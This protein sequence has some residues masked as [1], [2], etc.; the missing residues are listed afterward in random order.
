MQHEQETEQ[1]NE[2]PYQSGTIFAESGSGS[3]PIYSSHSSQQGQEYV[4]TCQK[5]DYDKALIN[6]KQDSVSDQIKLADCYFRGIGVEQDYTEAFKWYKKAADQGDFW[7]KSQLADCY[8]Y[9]N[10]VE[11]NYNQAVKWLEQVATQTLSDRLIDKLDK[12]GLHLF[13][14]EL[15]KADAKA[16]AQYQLGYCYYEGNGI[17]QDH[18][19]AVEWF[20]KAA[21]RNEEAK[22][23]LAECYLKGNGVKKDLTQGFN[24]LEEFTEKQENPLAQL[25]L[26]IRYYFC[27][28]MEQNRIRAISLFEKASNH[29]VFLPKFRQDKTQARTMLG[30]CYY[31]E[32]GVKD[33][34]SA[35][36]C[37]ESSSEERSEE[38]ND[39]VGHLWLASIYQLKNKQQFEG[40]NIEDNKQ[41]W[42]HPIHSEE[43]H[44]K[45]QQLDI[46]TLLCRAAAGFFLKDDGYDY[47]D[48][49]I[50]DFIFPKE[51]VI[52]FLEN[53]DFSYAKVILAF[54]YRCKNEKEKSLEL[55]KKADKENNIIASYELGKYYKELEY[56]D[57]ATEYL[58]AV[59]QRKNS[60]FNKEKDYYQ[61][62]Y[63]NQWLALLAKEEL[64]NIDFIK[65]QKELDIKNKALHEKEKEML[66]FF[67]HTMRNALATAPESLRQAI[68][69]LG[70]EDYESNQKHYEAINEITALFSTLTLTD[71]LIDTF[72]QSIYDTEEFKRAWQQDN[73]GDASPEWFI[74]AALRQSLNRIIFMEDATGLRKLINNQGEL[75]KPTRKAFIEQVLPLDVNQCDVEKFY[76]WLQSITAL[77]VTIEKSTV[78]FGANQIKFSLMFAISSELILNALKY[79]NGTGKIQIDWRIEPEHYIFS[80]SNACKANASSQLAGTHKGLAF[81]KRLIE[82][83][84]EQTQFNCS[85]NEHTFSAELKLHKTLLEG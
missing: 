50:I 75:I 2:F 31:H 34:G 9:G 11:Q 82:L 85:V 5:Q 76:Y 20:Q 69:L 13:W 17:K 71:C 49:D 38:R 35:L 8:F 67:T 36:R 1:G 39:S 41:P 74:A 62:K 7:A 37:F 30:I 14:Q 73:T 32:Y 10:G 4:N 52:E 66:S 25:K 19:Q 77:E 83:L 68:R 79:W 6:A 29:P 46:Y 45:Y 15:K 58:N 48:P 16:K 28:E 27:K 3:S 65:H 59:E 60:P 23:R 42:W 43:I 64:K 51:E 22:F 57:E 33:D 44:A 26:A 53:Q 72:K 40:L 78:Q 84:G 61:E 47:T 80:V 63:I 70:S 55:L 12:F 18:A 21:S 24:L 54:Y 81:I 56:F